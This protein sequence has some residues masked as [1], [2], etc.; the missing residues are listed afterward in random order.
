MKEEGVEGC[1]C[2]KEWT[3]RGKH[4][5]QSIL[6]LHS[7]EASAESAPLGLEGGGGAGAPGSGHMMLPGPGPAQAQPRPSPVNYL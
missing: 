6:R 2:G 3:D 1:L 5:G 4:S 7:K